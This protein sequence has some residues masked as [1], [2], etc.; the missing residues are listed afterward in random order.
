M[1]RIHS[2][3][4]YFIGLVII[5][6]LPFLFASCDKLS[7]VNKYA[8]KTLQVLKLFEEF[9]Y[10]YEELCY[11]RNLD[12]FLTES[13][14]IERLSN[15][16]ASLRAMDESINFG[17]LYGACEQSRLADSST[18]AA[19]KYLV[20]FYEAL[21]AISSKKVVTSNF[22]KLKGALKENTLV[23]IRENDVKQYERSV[24]VLVDI[25]TS[26]YRKQKITKALVENHEP[27]DSLFLL[28]E[29]CLDK[30]ENVAVTQVNLSSNIY[31]QYHMHTKGSVCC[32]L[33]VDRKFLLDRQRMKKEIRRIGVYRELVEAARSSLERAREVEFI[34]RS[35]KPIGLQPMGCKRLTLCENVLT[36]SIW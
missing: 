13:A 15:D 9:R 10:H 26:G 30:M 31:Q 17:T 3:F 28:F 34:K 16:Q 20:D 19:Y 18:Y 25:F 2:A 21:E 27:I 5:F 6:S 1:I 35:V 22:E 11:E 29:R 24:S 4:R 32:G 36:N 8:V 7:D 12:L 33:M 14:T 23:P